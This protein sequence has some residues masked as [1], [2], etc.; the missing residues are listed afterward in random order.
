MSV[1]FINLLLLLSGLLMRNSASTR[2]AS[3][4]DSGVAT[5]LFGGGDD[6]PLIIKLNLSWTT[7]LVVDLTATT[8]CSSSIHLYSSACGWPNGV[9]CGNLILINGSGTSPKQRYSLGNYFRVI[10]HLGLF[11]GPRVRR[12]SIDIIIVH[13]APLV[14]H[15][16]LVHLNRRHVRR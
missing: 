16:L 11:Y 3:T 2:T 1:P 5:A 6:N 14:F 12:S 13:L 7:N 10:T 4:R 9:T 8:S 15:Y